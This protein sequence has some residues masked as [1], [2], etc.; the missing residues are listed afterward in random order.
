MASFNKCIF[1]K[2]ISV[3]YKAVYVPK[4]AIEFFETL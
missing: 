3:G 2:G 1:L 4:S